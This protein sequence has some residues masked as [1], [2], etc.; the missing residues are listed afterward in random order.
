MGWE[1]YPDGLYETLQRVH[2][3]S[4]GIKM[5]VTENG[6]AFPDILSADGHVHDPDR[7]AYLERHVA[8]V[9]RAM[10]DGMSIAGYFVWSLLDNFEWTE[11]Y[12]PRFGI[13]YVDFQTQR[14]IV[15]DSGWWYANLI[16][17][18]SRTREGLR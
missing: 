15:K 2:H 7:I 9:K 10:D 12:R 13:V 14:R 18:A 6:A 8:Q 11:G 4:P 3:L 5:Y 17:S 1:V 16:R